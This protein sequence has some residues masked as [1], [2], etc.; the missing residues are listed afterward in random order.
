MEYQ[1]DK[2]P[3]IAL[4]SFEPNRLGQSTMEKAYLRTLPA[5]CVLANR[6]KEVSR[7]EKIKGG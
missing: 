4:R 6:D 7:E 2:H 5:A 3:R 1:K